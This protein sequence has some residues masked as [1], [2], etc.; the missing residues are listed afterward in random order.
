MAFLKKCFDQSSIFC[1]DRCRCW[2]Y[3]NNNLHVIDPEKNIYM[4]PHNDLLTNGDYELYRHHT[5]SFKKG[6]KQQ[7]T[8]RSV[9]KASLERFRTGLKTKNID[10][11]DSTCRF[12][13]VDPLSPHSVPVEY[14]RFLTKTIKPYTYESREFATDMLE[15]Y[16]MYL[17]RDV[18]F[19]DWSDQIDNTSYVLYDNFITANPTHNL[20]GES[21]GD[22][23]GY[24]ISQFML[25]DIPIWG[26]GK[27]KQQIAY[28]KSATDY[29]GTITEY[30]NQH[31]NG[32]L[33]A[34]PITTQINT[35]G[36]GGSASYR[37]VICGRDLAGY[38]NNDSPTQFIDN[39]LAILFSGFKQY[40]KTP[41]TGT[42]I[43][44]FNDFGVPCVAK[45][46][47]D[48]S[49]MALKCSFYH[50]FFLH[51]VLRP[52][53]FGYNIEKGYGKVDP[54][55]TNSAIL[56]KVKLSGNSLLPCAYPEGCPTHPSYPAGHAVIAG[57]GIT[58][59]KAF[60]DETASITDQRPDSTGSTLSQADSFSTPALASLTIGDELNKLAS[61]IGL[62]R[63]WAGIHYRMDTTFGIK[64]GED[65]AIYVLQQYK[66]TLP[67]PHTFS[68]SRYDGTTV[69]I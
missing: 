69:V 13:I 56:A 23:K 47:R 9:G 22:F 6:L 51:Q 52:E 39:A 4:C 60:F 40:L 26:I 42:M 17:M 2:D 12:N 68:F 7:I 59:L 57:A 45:L 38:V 49:L 34:Q 50:K 20:I 62:G 27:K 64:L 25:H 16:L 36:I 66:S 15:V 46:L 5:A 31:F 37:Y 61:N 48:A 33:P 11:I 3:R 54:S 32:V 18:N 24:H 55:L 28:Y 63:S 41:F 8:D 44:G 65:V 35:D 29:L 14:Q 58:I 10:M 19:T 30:E 21:A 67:Y 43:T 53:E 1:A